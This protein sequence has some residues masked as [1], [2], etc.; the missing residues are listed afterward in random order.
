MNA[1]TGL[2]GNSMGMS[3]IDCKAAIT[4]N[5]A[6]AIRKAVANQMVESGA[7]IAK[8]ALMGNDVNESMY[9]ELQNTKQKAAAGV[10]NL[11]RKIEQK[12]TRE[13]PRRR[14]LLKSQNSIEF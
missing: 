6:K 7:N 5:T 11:K 4:S 8:D 9:R 1:G 3:S 14:K 12:R 13:E 10:Q 2:N